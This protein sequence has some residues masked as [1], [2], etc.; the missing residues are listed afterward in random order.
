MRL[1]KKISIV[2]ISLISLS[3]F[4]KLSYCYGEKYA[5]LISAGLKSKEAALE[6]SEWWY[7][8]F[9]IYETL[10]EQGYTHDH[11]YVLYGYG[12]DSS[13]NISRYNVQTEHPT[14]PSITDYMVNNY[15]IESIFNW[16]ANGNDTEGIPKMTE[17]DDLFV[18]WFAHGN[19]NTVDWKCPN[20]YFSGDGFVAL[21]MNDEELRDII[22]QVNN[23]HIRSIFI[24]SCHGG[25]MIDDLEDLNNST[26]ISTVCL[27][28]EESHSTRY[29][30][31][32]GYEV[33]HFE[34][35][36]NLYKAL[37][38]K[39]PLGNIIDSN[40]DADANDDFR[41]TMNEVHDY[42][43]SN[44]TWNDSAAVYLSNPQL[45]DIDN[46]S[47]NYCVS[48]LELFDDMESGVGG[49]TATGLWH[50]V[51]NSSCISPGY[52]SP[53]TSWYYGQ[54]TSCNYNTGSRNTGS[55]TSPEIKGITSDST[56][57]FKYWRQV[58]SY[59]GS[60][61]RTYVEVSS[62]GGGTWTNVWHKDSRDASQAMWLQSEEISLTAFAG[63]SI[64]VRFTFDTVDGIS[65]G[66]N[67][68]FIDDVSVTSES[69]T[70]ATAYIDDMES[71]VGGWTAAGLWHQVS[72]SSCISP[73]YS[74]PTTSW[75]YGQDTSCNYNTGSRNTGS[76]TSPEIQGITSDS[77]LSFKYWRQVES[78]SGSYDKTYVEVSSDGGGTWTNV[79]NKDSRD[80]SQA[81]WLQAQEISLAA[82]AG[83]SISIRFTFDTVDSGYNNFNGWFIDD[84]SVTS[85]LS[86]GGG[87]VGAFIES[88][89]IV[90]ME[91]EHYTSTEQR[92]DDDTWYVESTTAG[93]LGDG[94]TTVGPD[95]NSANY[96]YDYGAIISYQVKINNPGTYYLRVRMYAC[97]GYCNSCWIGT[98]SG[99]I[100]SYYW[101][102]PPTY[103]NQWHWASYISG[104]TGFYLS[105][106]YHTINIVKRE[107]GMLIDRI[108]LAQN[109]GYL[110]SGT[111][112]GPSESPTE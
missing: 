30:S 46:L 92:Q 64:L 107:D 73:G 76:L 78:Y 95:D 93:Y 104:D 53:T 110:P 68:W 80:A 106:G 62:D 12:Y 51:S 20:I 25:G 87:G 77:K 10:I 44:R 111:E 9:L 14:W 38:G 81:M 67:G 82:F 31:I 8:L 15:Y 79:W 56:L 105:A 40:E 102:T 5:V 89:G 23:Y 27:C 60:Y 61:D 24:S 43:V 19:I 69:K 58:E 85:C 54:D 34:Y 83:N 50:Q 66:F 47:S 18:W 29:E 4:F 108:A 6:N 32:D 2:L 70:A 74:S 17:K 45:S 71:G 91:A 57:S 112:A 75:Y 39:D 16:L 109:S 94:Y 97:N 13:S 90:V 48:N 41:I 11:I 63:N 55:L 1:Q 86:G 28:E 88:N 103:Y 52:S 65:N 42:L 84:V 26:I 49:W 33:P 99:Q 96:G 59:S 7:D 35:N 22:N 3:L 100:G 21:V 101:N 36:L 98:E 72:N 37:S